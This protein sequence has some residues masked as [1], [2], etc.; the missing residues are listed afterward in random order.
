VLLG[1]LLRLEP[2]DLG[3]CLV[4]APEMTRLH[5]TFLRCAGPTDVLAFDYSLAGT[6]GARPAAALQGEICVC[7]DEAV[8]QARR[9]G[10]TWQ[11]ELIRYLVHGVLHLRGFDHHTAPARRRMK[12]EEERL[13]G[14]LARRFTLSR[15]ARP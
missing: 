4:A 15:L 6:R 7:L 8:R 3:I 13:L 9:Y 2:A 12:S 1:E 10:T 5:T 11:V 14:E